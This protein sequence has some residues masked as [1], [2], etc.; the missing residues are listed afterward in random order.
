MRIVA[1]LREIAEEKDITPAQLALAW[2][3]AQGD[4]IVPIPGTKRRSYLEENAG[5]S[6]RRADGRGPVADQRGTARG[7]GRALRGDRHGRSEPLMAGVTT[8]RANHDPVRLRDHCRGGGRS[9]GPDGKAGD[10]H[11]RRLGHRR[12]DGPRPRG[13]GCRWSPSRCAAR[14]TARRSRETSARA[15]ATTRSTVSHL[16]L[17]D[18][19]SIEAFVADWRRPARHPRQQ[20]RRDGDPGA[21]AHGPRPGDAVRDQPP[22]AFRPRARPARCAGRGWRRPDRLGQL[23]PATCA[24]R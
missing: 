16:E 23:Q 1:K 10:R 13:S 11:R 21:D 20:R 9:R 24:R 7:L 14:V 17:V 5:G 3:L 2:V 15:P 8:S 12:R 19:A 4:D 18:L 6:R 22:R